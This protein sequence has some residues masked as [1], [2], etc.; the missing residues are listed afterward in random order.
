MRRISSQ[1]I[2]DAEFRV[3]TGSRW[4]RWMDQL[5]NRQDRIAF[6][7]IV[8]AGS[9]VMCGL[10]MA[11]FL[12]NGPQ[13][14]MTFFGEA[15]P[16]P[17]LAASLAHVTIVGA[18]ILSCIACL[19]SESHKRLGVAG[20]VLSMMLVGSGC[21][22]QEQHTPRAGLT[23]EAQQAAKFDASLTPAKIIRNSDSSVM[24]IPTVKPHKE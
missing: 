16:A 21:A 3:I 19:F 2:I 17:A 7:M 23:L 6:G 4:N 9:I 18:V 5:P 10:T 15:G 8:A 14:I 1:D 24:Q 12:M 13:P 20:L 22:K 11:T